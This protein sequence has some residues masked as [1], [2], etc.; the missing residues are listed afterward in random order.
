MAL[1]RDG[2]PMDQSQDAFVRDTSCADAAA[3]GARRPEKMHVDIRDL[4]QV[5]TT[6]D[7]MPQRVQLVRMHVDTIRRRESH[8]GRPSLTLGSHTERKP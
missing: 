2:N 8:G 5:L 6:D 3:L 7:P 1:L 4:S